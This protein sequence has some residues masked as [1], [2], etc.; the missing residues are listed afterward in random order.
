V[1]LDNLEL[2]SKVREEL[3]LSSEERRSFD[4]FLIGVLSN[5]LS[6]EQWLDAL[7]TVSKSITTA[8]AKA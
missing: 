1:A 8:R 4:S 3:N 6:E 2:L 5:R 7:K